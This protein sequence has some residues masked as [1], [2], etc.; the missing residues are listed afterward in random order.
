MNGFFHRYIKRFME[1]A[2]EEKAV[3]HVTQQDASHVT[4]FI[5]EDGVMVL[6]LVAAN[7]SELLVRDVV[8]AISRMARGGTAITSGQPGQLL[9]QPPVVQTGAEPTAPHAIYPRLEKSEP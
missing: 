6:K 5:G 2:E 9:Q 4:S 1:L 7:S 3:Q 8:C